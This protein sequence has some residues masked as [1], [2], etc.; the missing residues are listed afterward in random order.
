MSEN[1]ECGFKLPH[2]FGVFSLQLLFNLNP[3]SCCSI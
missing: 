1:T 3:T 2:Y